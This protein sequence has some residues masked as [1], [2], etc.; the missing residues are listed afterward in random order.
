MIATVVNAAL[1]LAGS[2]IGLLFRKRI[3]QQFSD[4]IMAGLALCVAMIGIKSALGSNDTLCVIICMALGILLGEALRIEDKLDALGAFLKKRF[5]KGGGESR[6]TEAFMSAS[7]LFCMGS[8]AI[9]GSLEAGVKQDY[10]IIFSKSVIDGISA[11]TFSAAMGV[12]IAFSALAVLLYQGALTLLAIWIGPLLSGA[13]V[14]E[15]S[16]VGGL[17]IL[18]IAINMLG[19][20]GDR[21]VRVGNML[22]AMFLPVLYIP[23]A[24]WIGGLLG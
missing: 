22:P 1:I 2:F 20:M 24:A 18:G 6:F 13:V 4:A 17:L 5:I 10:T 19:L 15:M 11:V 12:G 9:M 7:L 8:M 23:A 16:A 3:K 21:K 14:A